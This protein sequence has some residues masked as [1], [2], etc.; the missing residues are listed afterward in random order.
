MED[1]PPI[2]EL[3][4]MIDEVVK[5]K[6]ESRLIAYSFKKLPLKTALSKMT[7]LD[8]WNQRLIR[9]WNIAKDF[10]EVTDG[11]W[12]SDAIANC[13][14]PTSTKGKLHYRQLKMCCMA[15]RDKRNRYTCLIELQGNLIY[16]ILAEVS[17]SFQN[18]G[19]MKDCV[20]M[21]KD[22]AFK[23]SCCDI[24]VGRADMPLKS[25][26][27]NKRPPAKD[28]R[29]EVNDETGNTHLLDCW[30]KTEN[31]FSINKY[32]GV[33]K[34]NAFAILSP[35]IVKEHDPIKYLEDNDYL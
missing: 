17:P 24:I 11:I 20:A 4:D 5:N 21:L 35:D 13:Q 14:I 16:L 26:Y 33:E 29:N 30:L 12:M 18:T 6:N 9:D 10:K 7:L 3:T 8:E 31:C 23:F 1:L 28:W 32:D 2:P 25:I 27:N 22:F 19:L 34:Y 15:I